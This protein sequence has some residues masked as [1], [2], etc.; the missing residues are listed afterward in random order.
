MGSLCFYFFS[1]LSWFLC[2][3]FVSLF[4]NEE[5]KEETGGEDQA[6]VQGGENHD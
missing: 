1:F 3:W 6:G 2:F 5:E 4:S